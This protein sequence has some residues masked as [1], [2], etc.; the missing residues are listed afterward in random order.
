MRR[1]A[2]LLLFGLVP[3]PIAAQIR[4]SERAEVSQTVDGTK[5]IV[6]YA[7]PR[8]RGRADLFGKVVEWDE[9][10]TPGAN[11]ATTLDVSKDIRI[12][13]HTLPKGKYSVWLVVK[14]QGDWIA[15]F[16]TTPN[17]FHLNRPVPDAAKLHY[18]LTPATGP[19]TEVLTFSFPDVTSGGTTLEMSWGT[20]RVDFPIVVQP[21][22]KRTIARDSVAPYLGSFQM[23]WTASAGGKPV[24]VPFV[25]RYSDADSTLRATTRTATEPETVEW[26]LIPV[27]KGVFTTALMMN[28]DIM[29]P[30]GQ[31]LLEFA[32]SSGASPTFQLRD[33]MDDKL[34][35]QGKRVNP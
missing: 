21:T 15:V 23:G 5:L 1:A 9:V 14:K 28:G 35:A 25:V 34:T 31:T 11:N 22:Q 32:V 20:T 10:W 19:F 7:R 24:S 8:A 16:D 2:L 18:A 12:S 29:E 17:R 30:G 26:M 13:G 33:K 3:L 27:S 6:N 4:P